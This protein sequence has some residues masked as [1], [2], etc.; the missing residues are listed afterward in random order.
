MPLTSSQWQQVE[1]LFGLAMQ[2]P[3]DHRYSWRHS[4]GSVDQQVGDEVDAL[5][6][7]CDE[8]ALRTPL[9]LACPASQ[10]SWRLPANDSAAPSASVCA[11]PGSVTS[12]GQP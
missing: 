5:I 4:A 9:S 6:A 2:L 8:G 11:P 7:T 10:D 1:T 3:I 12:A